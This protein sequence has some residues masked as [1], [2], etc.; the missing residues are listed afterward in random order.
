MDRQ[1]QHTWNTKRKT[2]SI[3]KK[4]SLVWLLTISLSIVLYL[5]CL[6]PYLS[7]WHSRGVPLP[8]GWVTRLPS[9]PHHK[10][11]THMA[12]PELL[13]TDV[14]RSC[15]GLGNC[16]LFCCCF[17]FFL[18]SSIFSHRDQQLIQISQSTPQ[19]ICILAGGWCWETATAFLV[20]KGNSSHHGGEV[21]SP[22]DLWYSYLL[23]LC[24]GSTGH[25]GRIGR[26]SLRSRQQSTGGNLPIPFCPGEESIRKRDE[27]WVKMTHAVTSERK[28]CE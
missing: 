11:Y 4:T 23:P 16:V 7:P 13:Q 8:Q 5:F 3:R 21:G 10:S 20:R 9:P 25:A 15:I 6:L 27:V 18:N 26:H 24:L 2:Q 19:D 14:I 17:C 22:A 28:G 1:W 12:A